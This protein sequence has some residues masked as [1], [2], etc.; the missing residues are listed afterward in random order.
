M[1]LSTHPMLLWLNVAL[2][3]AVNLAWATLFCVHG[4]PAT[5]GPG[6]HTG[7]GMAKGMAAVPASWPDHL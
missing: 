6:A 1:G 2:L 7:R 4:G 5:T 3:A